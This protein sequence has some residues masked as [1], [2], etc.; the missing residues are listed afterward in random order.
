M[1]Q[2]TT[3]PD[4][5]VPLPQRIIYGFGALAD[6]FIMNSFGTLVQPIYNI[7]L[8][9]DPVLLGLAI[10]IPRALD[11]VLDVLMGNLSDNTRTKWGRRRP[12]LVAGA[13][14]TAVV[15][16]VIWM[17]PVT[18]QNGMFLYLTLMTT[19]Y[20]GCYTVFTIP[21]A[22][23]GFELTSD[24]DE[25][26]RLLAWPNYIG[27]LG[28]IS[29]PWLYSIALL[30]VFGNEVTGAR[31]V[32]VVIAVIIIACGILP[33]IF[34]K[35]PQRT[36]QQEKIKLLEA[37]KITVRNRPF[38]IVVA[39]NL[40]V[41]LGLATMFG[42]G[43]YLNIY[44]VYGGDKMAAAKLS[45]I[46]G[47]LTAGMSYL[48]VMMATWLATRFGKR[49]AVEAGLVISLL[50]SLSLWW[51]LN[52]AMPYLQLIS[53]A[54]IGLGLQGCWMLFISMIGD[55]C[56]EDELET[57]LRREGIYSAV[58]GFTRKLAVAAAA[59]G[60]GAILKI[61]GFDATL[62]ETSGVAPDVLYRMKLLFIAGQ[63]AVLL[64]GIYLLRFYPITRAR[65]E[66]TQRKLRAR[67]AQKQAGA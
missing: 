14:L 20:F 25:R 12:Y 45:G 19:V 32:S 23:L 28:S 6:N 17:P 22:A 8:K 38:L 48:S 64:L 31:W 55:V 33:A 44:I 39:V 27:L 4:Q 18:T 53:S 65:A 15:L 11:A 52:P 35:E 26:T 46:G 1:S 51:T 59:L 24:Y 3:P 2:H 47:S 49:R 10:A 43:L 67:H 40:I 66:E 56:E 5:R 29:M 41:L 58:G 63:V 54:L 30:P 34:L 7:G 60:T 57:G 62:A 42:L 21:Y 50:G 16:P 36:Q 37:V 13:M 61:S 9:L